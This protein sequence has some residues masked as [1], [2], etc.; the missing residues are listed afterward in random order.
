MSFKE[1][2]DEFLDVDDGLAVTAMYNADTP[3]L[4]IFLNE[5]FPVPGEL[6]DTES[7]HPRFGC[8]AASL[9]N[10]VQGDTLE[11]DGTVYNITQI[12]P[13]GTGWL[14]LFLVKQ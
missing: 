1:E 7:S 5:Y 9:P 11:V 4:G 14:H 3:V 13:D 6:A 8:K 12:Q 10:V 2:L